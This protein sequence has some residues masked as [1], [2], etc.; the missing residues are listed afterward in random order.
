M[1]GLENAFFFDED[2]ARRYIEAK[3]WPDGPACTKCQSHNIIRMGGQTQPGMLLCRDCRNKFTCRMG[4]SMEHSHVPL[5]KWLLALSLATDGERYLSPQKL[6]RQLNLGS[7]RTAWFMAQ[8]I[9]EALSQHRRELD[10]HGCYRNQISSS[11]DR[12]ARACGCG[13]KFRISFEDALIA[14][15]ATRP[16]PRPRDK[17]K[18]K[19]AFPGGSSSI[20]TTTP[21][22]SFNL[23]VD[24]R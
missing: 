3:R 16:K 14:M 20:A 24:A 1:P 10:R 7:Y 23:G 12:S 18:R 4:T 17:P 21:T 13:E 11:S 9:R 19:D 2:F 15:L 5:H 22:V 8:R 6:M